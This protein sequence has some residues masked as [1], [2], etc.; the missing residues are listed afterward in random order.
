M[1]IEVRQLLNAD[2]VGI[3]QF[4]EKSNYKYGEFVSEDVI[5]PYKSAMSIKVNDYCFGENYALRY[6]K[7]RIQTIN[8]IYEVPL[9][10]CHKDILLRFN[11]KANLVIPLLQGEH[12][13]GLLCIH[14]CS[15]P[16]IWESSEIA[17]AKHIA[18]HL[19]VAIQQGEIIKNYQKQALYLQ[20][21]L[22]EVKQQKE[23]KIL[24]IKREKILARVIEK[25]RNSLE[26]KE[27]FKTTTQEVRNLL[28][29]DRVM[30]FQFI[31]ETLFSQGEV[32]AENV[33]PPYLNLLK[34]RVIDECFGD[35]YAIAYK[36]GKINAISDIFQES[37][38]DCHRDILAQ[39]QVKA[40]L[41]IPILKGNQLW[42]LL[43]IHQCSKPRQWEEIEINFAKQIAIHLGVALL[44][45]DQF[46]TLQEQSQELS[47]AVE[48][49]K[50]VGKIINKIRRSLDLKTIFK[51]STKELQ[52]LLN[53][54]RVAIYRFNE[55]WSGEFIVDSVA[56]G[57][58]SLLNHQESNPQ[59]KQ[60]ISDCTVKKLGNPQFTDT[61]LQQTQ[62]G[63]FTPQDFYRVCD[64]IYQA[65]FSQCYIEILE[66]YQVKAYAIVAIYH[67]QKLW[68]L[69][70]AYQ[71]SNSRHWLNSEINFLIQ[72]GANLSVAI[73]QAELLSQAQ[74]RSEKLQT[75]L[76]QQLQQR[77]EEL[78]EETQ[79]EKVLSEVIDK[80]RQ[81]LDIDTIFKT[82][83]EEV[84]QLLN[85]DRVG[86]FQ[87]LN[88]NHIEGKFVSENVS[89]D[90]PSL[91]DL[92]I[93]DRCFSENIMEFYKKGKSKATNDIYKEG[94]SDCHI[95]LL[96]QF[97][98]KAN[99][100]VP[101]IKNQELWG[102]LCIHQCSNSRLWQEKDIEF[103]EKIAI[104]LGVALQQTELLIQARNRSGELQ[105]ALAEVESQKEQEQA[106]TKVIEKIRQS[107]DLE[108]IFQ[109][110]VTEVR[111]LLNADRVAIFKFDLDSNYNKGKFISEDVVPQFTSAYQS[112]LEDH[113]FGEN[114]ATYYQQGRIF[115][116]DNIYE[117]GL[118]DCHIQILSQF[119]VKANMVA[120]LLKGE[121][122]WGLLCIHKCDQP[123]Q[124]EEKEVEFI[125]KIAVQLGVAL[126]QV[127]LLDKSQKNSIELRSTLAD[128]NA[129][130]D[131]LADGLLVTDIQG[132]ITR[133]NPALLK[134]F[135]LQNLNL[136]GCQLS[137][138]FPNE[139]AHLVEQAEGVN[140]EIVTVNVELPQNRA[141]QALATSIIKEAHG[142]EGE[143]CI[144]SVILIRDV[145]MEREVDRMKTDFLATVSHELRTPL[146]SVLGFASIIEDK[147]KNVLFP[148]LPIENNPKIN[149]AVQRVN[150]NIHIIISEAERLTTLINDVLDIAK[151]EAGRIDWNIEK[152]DP[153][154]IL[155]TAISA[156][157]FLFHNSNVILIKKIEPNLPLIMADRDR[158]IQVFINL[159]SNAIKFT[160]KGEI[161][162]EINSTQEKLIVSIKDTGIGIAPENYETIFQRFGQV[163][164]ILTGKPKGT[165]LGLPIC[166]QIIEHHGGK[167]WVESN[168]GKGSTFF[169][170]IPIDKL[171]VENSLT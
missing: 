48:R 119:Q 140:Q 138:Y 122:L 8:N 49:E 99:L 130:V 143:Q 78:A 169:F 21:S 62:G 125:S 157:S 43:C 28:N 171:S 46:K 133:F 91:L 92:T 131:N 9:S 56:S 50:A 135:N 12:L 167:I 154:E 24:A 76:T 127:N 136:I 70:A 53:V 2:R 170:T 155:Q 128:L 87:F 90:Y 117:I 1:R 109:T 31:P 139:L 89:N 38:S 34:K 86:V 96:A 114:Y 72:I 17:F 52:K 151:M 26:L 67:G 103:V 18:L 22:A 97:K 55:D 81:T 37:I 156:T 14:Q 101:I 25:I 10:D 23:Q 113:C 160:E 45:V 88:N 32:V 59:L 166:K 147:L 153:R 20:L 79:R 68:G 100:I 36:E 165:G 104:Q 77:A 54:D 152:S 168:L 111:Q 159:L 98:I 58:V 5:F 106:L 141:G 107:L 118:S 35:K 47:L 84:R 158:L 61:Y 65:E 108:T 11:V 110:S 149:K 29:A 69:L 116:T 71:N 74:T 164:D 132:N 120:P 115:S 145:T 126:Q 93:V 148:L 63:S 123:R 95:E 129:I 112:K 27:I 13:W 137:T 3:F 4:D 105:I 73:Q 121:E 80:I 33:A 57:W 94:F 39:F 124:W 7:G 144:G 83:T 161:I 51:T 163:G 44:Q 60:N 146:T 82:A 66:L 15:K 41:A 16:R 6:Q 150:G 162:C 75:T 64:D 85:V 102:L 142:D 40:N 30:V 19:G 134:M 42:G